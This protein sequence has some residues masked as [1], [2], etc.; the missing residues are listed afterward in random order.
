MH[1]VVCTSMMCRLR[2]RTKNVTVAGIIVYYIIR[3][4][5]NDVLEPAPQSHS[6]Q[7]K[8][9]LTVSNNCICPLQYENYSARSTL[10]LG[11]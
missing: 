8:F 3:I 11:Y 9:T 4:V 1:N 7:S 10:S 6:C 5:L 2:E